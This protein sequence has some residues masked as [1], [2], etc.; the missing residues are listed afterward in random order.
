MRADTGLGL[1]LEHREGTPPVTICSC[2]ALQS[3]QSLQTLQSAAKCQP[4]LIML[5]GFFPFCLY[6]R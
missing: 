5:S 4:R 6:P 2:N 3:L 1:T